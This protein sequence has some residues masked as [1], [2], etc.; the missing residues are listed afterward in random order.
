M[1]AIVITDSTGH[2]HYHPLSLENGRSYAIGRS[3]TCD[4]S[5]PA[6]STL[7]DVHCFLT[8]SEGYVYLQD[9]N[10][11]NGIQ[12]AA[13]AISAEYMNY[14]KEY[15]L[16]GCRLMLIY[17]EDATAQVA[18]A[19]PVRKVA[20]LK[21]KA[22]TATAAAP[23][24]PIPAAEPAP[25]VPVRKVAKLKPKNVTPAPTPAP[26]YTAPEAAYYQEP[27][28]APVEAYA[29]PAA[30]E[31]VYSEPADVEAPAPQEPVY[32][33]PAAVEAPAP[34]EP[35]YSEPP[36]V[37]APA[38]QES[39][40]SEPA[41]V[42]AP[43]AQTAEPEKSETK[44]TSAPQ[45]AKPGK[46]SS[47][48]TK[49]KAVSKKGKYRKVGHVHK[50]PG[51]LPE[52][53]RSGAIANLPTAFGLKLRLASSQPELKIGSELRFALTAERDCYIYLVEYDC[54]GNVGLLVPGMAG[55]DNKLFANTESIFPGLANTDYSLMVEPPSGQ[56]TLI[57]VACTDPG[58][59]EKVWKE[60]IEKSTDPLSPGQAEQQ[61]ISSCKTADKPWSSAFIYFVTVD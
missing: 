19:T 61:A 8:I 23:A 38:P 2:T 42:E 14:E 1:L 60:I 6:E 11:T 59:F 55:I 54:E 31:P 43:A 5:L 36:A 53:P 39:V 34:L 4:F 21:P 10:S 13:G 49:K 51:Y 12:T 57:A 9:N 26:T 52:P 22:V 18:P 17:T 37:E 7:S 45:K 15:I 28:P 20:K 27:A 30:Q 48:T 46:S 35:V 50:S 44:T 58:N 47:V 40:Y 32:S 29:Y 56:E 16:G 41:A 33:E 25:A 24:E 3:E